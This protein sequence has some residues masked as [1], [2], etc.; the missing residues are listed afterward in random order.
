[1]RYAQ[2]L[3]RLR[4]GHTCKVAELYESRFL[5]IF[6]MESLERGGEGFEIHGFVIR[7]D[8]RLA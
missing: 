7:S 1:V 5:R 2:R 4:D 6:C 8:G 3:S